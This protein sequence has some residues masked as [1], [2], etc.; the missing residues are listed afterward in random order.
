M[1]SRRDLRRELRRRLQTVAE[2]PELEA[3]LI[4]T[5]ALAISRAELLADPGEPVDPERVRLVEHLLACRLQGKPLPYVLGEWEFYGYRLKVTPAVLIPRPETETLV[6]AALEAIPPD[7]EDLAV[8][9]GTGSGAVAIALAGA[10]PHI[11]VAA[12]DIS[13]AALAVARENISRYGLD[14]RIELYY[15]DLLLPLKD[16]LKSERPLAVVANLPYVPTA[17][18][19]K[20]AWEPPA[21]LDGGPDGLLVIRRFL[22]QARDLLPPG[23]PVFLE[24][25]YGQA[26]EVSAEVRRRFPDATVTVRPDLAGIPRVVGFLTGHHRQGSPAAS[27]SPDLTS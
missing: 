22:D 12:T 11:T 13:P 21:A 23:V 1:V 25:G 10:R 6:E 19:A 8:D 2:D 17:E 27:L 4:L 9:V 26:G 14:R 24:V 18:T 3:D 15:G 5:R 7:V 20:L 16:R